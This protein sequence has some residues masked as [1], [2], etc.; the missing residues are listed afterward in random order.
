MLGGRY[1]AHARN[2]TCNRD[3]EILHVIWSVPDHLAHIAGFSS[4]RILKTAHLLTGMLLVLLEAP[5]SAVIVALA[6]T[7]QA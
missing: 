7:N 6:I 4:Q 5:E 3:A 2:E 1:R